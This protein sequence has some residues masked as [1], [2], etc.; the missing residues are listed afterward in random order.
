MLHAK[1]VQPASACRQH[2]CLIEATS[3]HL[4]AD[5]EAWIVDNVRDEGFFSVT[6]HRF[7]GGVKVKHV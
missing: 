7:F 2:L 6:V 3:T 5:V 4:P 1:H